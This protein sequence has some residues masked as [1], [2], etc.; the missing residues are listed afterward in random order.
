MYETSTR[1]LARGFATL[2][3][4]R[5]YDEIRVTMQRLGSLTASSDLFSAPS[6]HWDVAAQVGAEGCFGLAVR[7]RFGVALKSF[8]G[9]ERPLGPAILDVMTRLGVAPALTY[10][11]YRPSFDVALRGGRDVVGHVESMVRLS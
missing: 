5:R 8:D 7:G 6:C 9:S 3:T 10:E 4:D 11:G 2:A 1:E